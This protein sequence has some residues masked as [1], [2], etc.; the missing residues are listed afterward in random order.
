MRQRE[1]LM[2]IK[3]IAWM[4]AVMM[5]SSL[6]LVACDVTESDTAAIESSEKIQKETLSES[7][8]TC[9][10]ENAT[11]EKCD[12][13]PENPETEASA[14]A[15]VLEVIP[16]FSSEMTVKWYEPEEYL[17][18]FGDIV[19]N[20][21]DYSFVIR[22]KSEAELSAFDAKI[23]NRG[24]IDVEE[25]FFENNDLFVI[26]SIQGSGS[27]ELVFDSCRLNR[28]S[29]EPQIEFN[30][31]ALSPFGHTTDIK[32]WFVCVGVPKSVLDDTVMP[33]VKITAEFYGE[34]YY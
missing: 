16:T 6:A 25:G 20:P 30:I 12:Q 13:L 24:I 29:D 2:K 10:S 33:I 5:L 21:Q 11:T 1:V 15:D 4:L 17:A 9:K 23:W 34:E 8:S 27:I 18:L 19:L 7:Q 26:Y 3:A 31:R 14:D 22:L 32:C 28:S